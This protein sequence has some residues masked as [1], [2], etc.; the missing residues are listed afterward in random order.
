MS[1]DSEW[2]STEGITCRRCGAE[3]KDGLALEQVWAPGLPYWPG[4]KHGI[5]MHLA[6]T[7]RTVPCL[8]C[9]ECGRS[10]AQ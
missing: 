1:D 10:I 7:G 8:K 9:P 3:M 4:D 6:T 2:V 5:T